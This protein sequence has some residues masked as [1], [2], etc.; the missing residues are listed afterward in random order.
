MEA[1]MSQLSESEKQP[2]RSLW[3][4]RLEPDGGEGNESGVGLRTKQVTSAKGDFHLPFWFRDL[5][6]AAK[7]IGRQIWCASPEVS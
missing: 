6:A 2:E 3:C 1:M 7:L 4:E 5:P